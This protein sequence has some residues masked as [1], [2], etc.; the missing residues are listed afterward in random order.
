MEINI[1]SNTNVARAVSRVLPKYELVEIIKKLLRQLK[2]GKNVELSL[3]FVDNIAIRKLNKKYRKKDK[4][5]DVL[6]FAPCEAKDFIL[7]YEMLGEI[8]I[9]VEMAKQQARELNTV[10]REEIL[11]LL[12]HGILHLCGYEHEN[13]SKQEGS[14][15]QRMEDKLFELVLRAD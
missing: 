11:R 10:L 14:K 2:C 15:M 4:A 3:L 5:T 9:S 13:V 1:S 8:I 6:S 12:I 7:P